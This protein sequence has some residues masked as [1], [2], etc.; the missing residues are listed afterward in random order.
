MSAI[1]WAVVPFGAGVGHGQGGHDAG[2]GEHHVAVAGLLR[3]EH[4]EVSAEE[5]ACW[6]EA[7]CTSACGGR[8]RQPGEVGHSHADAVHLRHVVGLRGAGG[9]GRSRWCRVAHAA[10]QRVPDEPLSV[11][12]RRVAA[13]GQNERQSSWIPSY[14]PSGLDRPRTAYTRRGFP[15]ERRSEGAGEREAPRRPKVPRRGMLRVEKRLLAQQA[16]RRRS[17]I[18]AGLPGVREQRVALQVRLQVGEGLRRLRSLARSRPCWA[19]QG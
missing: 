2:G 5:S 4:V 8:G 12:R 17:R 10:R 18:P 3:Q 14:V 11:G 19:R 9:V 15:G 6:L 7:A 13:S 16:V 1:S